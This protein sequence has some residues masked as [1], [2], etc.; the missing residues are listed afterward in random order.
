MGLATKESSGFY[1]AYGQKIMRTRDTLRLETC[2]G[3][4]WTTQLALLLRLKIWRDMV[5]MVEVPECDKAVESLA[6][7]TKREVLTQLDVLIAQMKDIAS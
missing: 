7:E 1:R 2:E 4:F 5:Q 3:L 6:A